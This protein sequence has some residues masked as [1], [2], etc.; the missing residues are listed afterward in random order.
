MQVLQ[1]IYTSLNTFIGVSYWCYIKHV[2]VLRWL[3]ESENESDNE[4]GSKSD[5]DGESESE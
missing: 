2:H 5:S 3:S 4:T 1:D